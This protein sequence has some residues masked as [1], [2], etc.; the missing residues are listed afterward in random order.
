MWGEGSSRRG[1][2]THAGWR[3]CGL[4]PRQQKFHYTAAALPDAIT[5]SALTAAPDSCPPRSPQLQPL[6]PPQ[7]TRLRSAAPHTSASP[8]PSGRD[9]RH[10]RAEGWRLAHRQAGWRRQNAQSTLR[11]STWCLWQRTLQLSNRRPTQAAPLPSNPPSN[12]ALTLQT[13]LVKQHG[14]S[15]SGYNQAMSEP[16]QPAPS[17]QTLPSKQ[18]Q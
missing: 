8:A 13:Y 17:P 12:P 7:S 14:P 15:G 10:G 1:T 16:A 18:T 11:G 3:L 6:T 5:P 2:S 4:H 9:G